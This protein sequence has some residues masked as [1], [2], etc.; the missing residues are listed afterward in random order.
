L[1]YFVRFGVLWFIAYRAKKGCRC[2]C[3]FFV[4]RFCSMPTAPSSLD[5][6]MD[7]DR[8]DEPVAA[9]SLWSAQNCSPALA[10]WRPLHCRCAGCCNLRATRG[11]GLLY[12]VYQHFSAWMTS[13]TRA[14]P[15]S[16][17]SGC[18]WAGASASR[19]SSGGQFLRAMLRA[20]TADLLHC[21]RRRLPAFWCPAGTS[22]LLSAAIFRAC[23]VHGTRSR[24][25]FHRL[26]RAGGLP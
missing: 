24:D 1:L 16:P 15:S 7:R 4:R 10:R 9:L 6:R 21:G 19:L 26:P 5:D 25:Q 2:L 3:A 17:W 22:C 12:I 13:G 20:A 8:T 11:F 18:C 23:R 14:R